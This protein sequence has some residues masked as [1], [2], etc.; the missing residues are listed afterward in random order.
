MPGVCLSVCQL[1]TLRKTTERI[2]M[3]ILPQTYPWITKSRLN[4]GSNPDPES[5]SGFRIRT[6]DSGQILLAGDAVSD[7]SCC[8]LLLSCNHHHNAAAAAADVSLVVRRYWAATKCEV[9]LH[10][11]VIEASISASAGPGRTLT[12][13][14]NDGQHQAACSRLL[15]Q[16]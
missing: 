15:R 6:P 10:T 14:D 5:R 3:K 8:F 7:C 2:F 4:S 12:V 1:A 9:K 11:F 13:S 16:R